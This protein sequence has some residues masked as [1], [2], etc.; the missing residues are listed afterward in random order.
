[1]EPITHFL[2]GATLARAGFNRKTALATVTMMLAAEAADLDMV[3]GWHGRAAGF[4]AHRGFT[5]TFWAVPLVAA[6]VV[7]VVWLGD[8]L[9][10]RLRPPMSR[11]IAARRWGLLYLFACLAAL[12]H[13]LL[14]FTNNYGVRPFYPL[15]RTWYAWDIVYIFEPLIFLALVAALALP[16]LFRLISHETAYRAEQPAGRTAAV[17]ALLF[18]IALWGLRDFEHRRA[19]AAVNAFDYRG[20]RAVRVAAFPYMVNPFHWAGVA[21]TPSAIFVMHVDSRQPAVDANAG[22]QTYDKPQSTP[23]TQAA[24]QTALGRGYL[25]WAR[26]PLIDSETLPAPEAGY[27]VHFQDLRFAY[28]DSPRRILHAYIKL[29]EHLHER[30]AGFEPMRR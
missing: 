12:L 29:D 27:L 9:W 18:I 15:V 2:A 22:M 23:A 13:L 5:H 14:D 17:L 28:P 24:R 16:G 11:T 10:H 3:A 26:F 7:G 19:V 1:M 8:R 4:L 20:A 6:V 25:E 30:A 21:E